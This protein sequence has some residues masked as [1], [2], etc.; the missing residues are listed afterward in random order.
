MVGRRSSA[1]G[2]HGNGKR[3]RGGPGGSGGLDTILILDF[4]GQYCHLIG[5]RVRE[6]RVY[7]EIAPPDISPE[8][9]TA[10]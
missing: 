6:L 2:A 9:I 3:A 1:E 5:R 8:G 7:S 4:G 10:M